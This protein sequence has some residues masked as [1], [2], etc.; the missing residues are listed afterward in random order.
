[1][2]A[3]LGTNLWACLGGGEGWRHGDLGEALVLGHLC[4]ECLSS[5]LRDSV[6]GKHLP[7]CVRV[8]RCSRPSPATPQRRDSP[9]PGRAWDTAPH[10]FLPPLW[11][12]L[13]L[14]SEV[15]STVQP[16]SRPPPREGLETRQSHPLCG[17]PW[18][19]RVQLCPEGD[20]L[21][22]RDACVQKTLMLQPG[23]CTNKWGLAFLARMRLGQ[24][25]TRCRLQGAA[26]LSQGGAAA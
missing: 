14:S 20:S 15:P 10:C 16:A 21:L 4:K 11:P 18:P 25:T 19:P 7:L 23:Q 13:T 2:G 3:L 5:P 9:K 26:P 1:M 22:Q 6:W 24:M 8:W 17:P 12:A